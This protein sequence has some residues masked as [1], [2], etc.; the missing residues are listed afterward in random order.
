MSPKTRL[1]ACSAIILLS[2]ITGGS[3][4]FAQRIQV[5]AFV[6]EPFGVGRLQLDLPPTMLPQPLGAEGLGVVEQDGRVL[7][8]E[9]QGCWFPNYWR[10]RR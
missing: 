8:V 5:D 3:A 7:R 1:L 10:G 4:A 6:G 9:M 2:V